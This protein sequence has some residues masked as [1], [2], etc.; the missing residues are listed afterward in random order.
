M[1]AVTTAL[2]IVWLQPMRTP[3]HN[4]LGLCSFSPKQ[5]RVLP[6][7]PRKLAIPGAYRCHPAHGQGMHDG[8]EHAV[9]QVRVSATVSGK[10][11]HAC[12]L[13]CNIAS[14]RR[15]LIRISLSFCIYMYIYIYHACMH[16]CMYAPQGPR[17]RRTVLRGHGSLQRCLLEGLRFRRPVPRVGVSHLRAWGSHV[18]WH[19]HGRDAHSIRAVADGEAYAGQL[20]VVPRAQRAPQHIAVLSPLLLPRYSWVLSCKAAA[21]GTMH[22]ACR[23]IKMR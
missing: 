14:R 9:V 12:M 23:V 2:H 7:N 11:M 5:A 10:D 15:P 6:Y 4:A 3:A 22:R 20:C 1:V 8:A 13:Y 16:T 17:D 18:T 19:C 21:R